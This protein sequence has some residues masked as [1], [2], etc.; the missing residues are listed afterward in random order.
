MNYIL[1]NFK[2]IAVVAGISSLPAIYFANRAPAMEDCQTE[3][4][5]KNNREIKEFQAQIKTDDGQHF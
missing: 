2:L 1:Q 3:Y 5:K 4:A